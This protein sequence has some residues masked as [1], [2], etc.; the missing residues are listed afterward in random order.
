MCVCVRKAQRNRERASGLV[1]D[2]K[3]T[4]SKQGM[5]YLVKLD[6]Y[7]FND[8]DVLQINLLNGSE[9]LQQLCQSQQTRI[10]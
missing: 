3:E 8:F 4:G 6:I 1:D 9:D 7:E 5:R 10:K 2:E